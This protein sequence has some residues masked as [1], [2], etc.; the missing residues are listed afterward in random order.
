LNFFF[1]FLLF[2]LF[3]FLFFSR[4]FRAPTAP[5]R[6]RIL[7]PHDPLS[8]RFEALFLQETYLGSAERWP[9]RGAS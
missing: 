2:F 7:M 4:I 1:F 6:T 8:M 5:L 3:F 9:S